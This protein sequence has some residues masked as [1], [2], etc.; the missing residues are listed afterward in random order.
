MWASAVDCSEFACKLPG[1]QASYPA[2]V[3]SSG[4]QQGLRTGAAGLPG[5]SA[6]H[7]WPASHSRSSSSLCRWEDCSVWRFT[8]VPASW[9]GCG[10]SNFQ[11]ASTLHTH[12]ASAF[13]SVGWAQLYAAQV[14]PCLVLIV[15]CCG[16]CGTAPVLCGHMCRRHGACA[17][18]TINSCSP[19]AFLQSG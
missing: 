10:V 15:L 9:C 12:Q 13:H 1:Q 4:N 16:A 14:L 11:F 5:S 3:Q 8:A 19:N 6:C 2:A 18:T 17:F 7:V